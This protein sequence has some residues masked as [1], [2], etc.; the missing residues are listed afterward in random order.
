[1][2]G[3]RAGA[4][5]G[6]AG[7]GGAAGGKAGAGGGSAGAGGGSAGA[8]GGNAGS[9]GGSAGAGGGSAGAGGGSAGA[10]AGGSAVGGNTVCFPTPI[11][12]PG[13]SGPPDWWVGTAPFDDPRWN[14]A[15]AFGFANVTFDALLDNTA[16]PAALVLRWHVASDPGI[17]GPGDAVWVG[18][19]NT[20]T[21]L[22]TVLQ[23]TRDTLTTTTAG[24]I[25]A[26]VMSAAAFQKTETAAIWGSV[27]V[28]STIATDA[29]LDAVC[30]SSVD[31]V[32]CPSWTIRL[33]VPM[34]AA[35][36]GIDLGPSFLMWSEVDVKNNTNATT[37][38]N[39]WPVGAAVV[40][41]TADPLTFPDPR[42]S[43][44]PVSIP[45]FTV[46]TN[47]GTCAPAITLG[48]EDLTVTN[49]IGTGTTIDVAG[50]NTFHVRPLN[51]TQTPFTATAIGATLRIADW[52]SG[53]GDSPLWL[54]FPDA[55][56][57][58]AGGS[59]GIVGNGARFDLTCT[60][61][62]TAA[63]GCDYRPDLAPGCTPEAIG[64]RFAQQGILV[65]L[66]STAAPIAFASG[67]AAATF[68]FAAH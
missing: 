44:T 55:S 40:D 62:P 56:C 45:W 28:P 4:G 51:Q 42:G 36:G 18:F 13:Q 31:P 17:A 41:P 38:A 20:T 15:Y 43:T 32:V 49:Q 63:Q 67:S 37:T 19:F 46:S 52:R 66:S 24:G 50:A 47:G 27:A 16:Q 61:T 10:G 12:V 64:T 68:G 8:G 33:R 5:G 34:T 60:W 59:G 1:V 21:N 39:S 11:G 30:D 29:R 23:L 57:A 48:P 9:G 14:G 22:G 35:A 53:V 6:N 25:G 54:P 7:A 26:G 3:G 65:E 2:G 58:A